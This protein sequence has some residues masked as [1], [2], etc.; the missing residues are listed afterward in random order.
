[1]GQRHE[2]TAATVTHCLP[3]PFVTAYRL[4]G[5]CKAVALTMPGSVRRGRCDCTLNHSRSPT[6]TRHQVAIGKASR[7]LAQ[8]Q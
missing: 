2:G 1:M 7:C 3:P 4:I 8:S 6:G 5:W